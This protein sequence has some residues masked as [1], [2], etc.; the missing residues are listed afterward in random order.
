MQDRLTIKM[1]LQSQLDLVD[2]QID[3]L[4]TKI[5]NSKSLKKQFYYQEKTI[6]DK[7]GATTKE[8]F[9]EDMQPLRLLQQNLQQAIDDINA[10][11]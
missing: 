11:L 2:L 3:K 6:T 1:Y 7:N 8:V 10:G 5:L 4:K 9:F